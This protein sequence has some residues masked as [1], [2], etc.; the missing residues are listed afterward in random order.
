VASQGAL[1]ALIEALEAEQARRRKAQF[2]EHGDP[3]QWLLEELEGMAQKFAAT[4][5]RW[6]L[7]LADMSIMEKL[8]C[9]L[10][11]RH[12]QPVELPGED[13]ILAELIT[14][15]TPLS[16]AGGRGRNWLPHVPRDRDHGLSCQW[17]SA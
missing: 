17:R 15:I 8:A 3:H 4:A 16:G 6:P 2:G 13:A 1:K 9:H 10:L 5:H 7:N 12:L 14:I 11:L